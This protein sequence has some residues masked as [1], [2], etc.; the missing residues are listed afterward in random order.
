MKKLLLVAALYGLIVLSAGCGGEKTYKTDEGTVKVD[1][2]KVEVTTRDGVKSKLTVD[3]G[4]GVSLPEGYPENVV[5]IMG[6]GKVIMANKNEDDQKKT[7][8]WITVRSEKDPQEIFKFYQEAV[9]DDT[10][11]QKTQMNND[12]FVSGVKGEREFTISVTS[13]GKNQ[14][15]SVIQIFVGP[16]K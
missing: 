1:G 4:G 8:F 10:E 13:D 2:N 14:K 12:Y 16:N 5:P 3:E 9:K 7:S 15:Q 11:T 6:G